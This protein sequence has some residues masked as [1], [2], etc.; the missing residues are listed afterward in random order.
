MKDDSN[1]EKQRRRKRLNQLLHAAPKGR[2]SIKPSVEAEEIAHQYHNLKIE[3]NKVKDENFSLK[4]SLV[5]LK[6]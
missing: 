2:L 6:E 4:T 5:K 3:L 1:L